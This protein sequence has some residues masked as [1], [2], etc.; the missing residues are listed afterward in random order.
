M[1]DRAAS[2]AT[3]PVEAAASAEARPS[4]KA[5]SVEATTAETATSIVS[6]ATVEPAAAIEAM[7]PRT[8][9]DEDPADEVV[10]AVVAIR[11][12]SVGVIPVVA[13]FAGCTRT[14]V[15]RANA[16]IDSLCV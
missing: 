8:G 16:D 2:E 14:N 5:A 4:V 11:S 6:A 12:T 7:E 9:A 3:A 13:V 15:A 1:T 10:R